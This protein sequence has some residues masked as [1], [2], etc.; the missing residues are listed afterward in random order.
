VYNSEDEGRAF[1]DS[2]VGAENDYDD[3]V[4]CDNDDLKCPWNS[5]EGLV[6]VE[7]AVHMFMKKMKEYGHVCSIC[8]ERAHNTKPVVLKHMMDWVI[9]D[10]AEQISDSLYPQFPDKHI[11]RK[12]N[13]S[14]GCLNI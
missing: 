8:G 6:K 10:E 7:R 1:S 3:D 9:A 11:D 5:P 13:S 12:V 4:E 14:T 2:D